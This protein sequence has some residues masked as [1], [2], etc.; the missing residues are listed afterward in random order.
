VPR[1]WAVGISNGAL[2]A[3]AGRGSHHGTATV[4]TTRAALGEFVLQPT[5]DTL[6]ELVASGA[7]SVVGDRQA[8]DQLVAVCDT[9]SLW[10][11]LIEPRPNRP[12]H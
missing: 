12:A 9:F 1:E 7:L 8:I 3:T 10:F 4:T 11:G 5:A 6:D 2:Y